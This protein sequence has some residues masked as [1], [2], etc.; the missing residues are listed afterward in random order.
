MYEDLSHGELVEKVRELENQ[1]AELKQ[2]FEIF[3]N[4]VAQKIE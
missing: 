2:K 4:Q 3:Q 1:V